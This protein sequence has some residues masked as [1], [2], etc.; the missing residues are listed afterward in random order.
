MADVFISYKSERRAA[1]EHLAEI[2]ADYGYSVWWD[3]GLISG[4][5]FGA[6][7]EKELRAAK[8]V[9]VLWCSMSVSS[10]W[11]REEAA[12]AKRL[13]RVIPTFIEHG[14]ELPLGFSLSQTL[15]LADWDGAPKSA[16]LDR[17]LR[18]IAQLV[19]R[20][21]RPNLPG[22][23]R[24]ERAWRRFGAP[25]LRD[26]ALIDALERKQ[27]ARTLPGSLF[28]QD[29]SAV[30]NDPVRRSSPMLFVVAAAALLAVGGFAAYSFLPQLRG[31]AL[32]TPQERQ[33]SQENQE[34]QESQANM[35]AGGSTQRQTAT[36]GQPPSTTAGAQAP[37]VTAGAQA[38][39]AAARTPSPPAPGERFSDCA[40]CPEMV[41]LPAG[42]FTMGSPA[43]EA[44][45]RVDERQTR[46]TIAQNFAVSQFEVTRAQYGAFIRAAGHPD[47]GNCYTDRDDD[48]GFVQDASGTWRNPGMT[49]GEDHPVVCVSWHDAQAYARWL[50]STTGHAYRL[51]SEAEWEYAARGGDRAG[52]Y[53]W[54]ARLGRQ[55]AN[56]GSDSCC[57]GYASGA[58]RWVH[59]SPAGSFAANPFG[60]FDMHGNVWEWVQDCYNAGE[61][62]CPQRV[63]RGGSWNFDPAGLRSAV[64]EKGPPGN[65]SVNVGFRVARTLD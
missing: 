6:Q 50:S 16:R 7:I 1:A 9:V 32:Q 4:R 10:E 62:G 53:P 34:N 45:R 20:A 55:N 43:S 31:G 14:V 8:A 38:P 40:E 44:G 15:D 28:K 17:L 39:P 47:G 58:D 51:L 48:G 63:F 13:N 23:E 35:S 11:V 61:A 36:D 3:Y 19:G 49:Q 25:P 5:D 56:Y 2:L 42:S 46:V 37:P 27:P 65:R 54:G 60:L 59:T 33:E 21:A 41:V 29:G 24:T 52:P 12:L 57:Y 64:R 22:L 26:F 18:D 30:R